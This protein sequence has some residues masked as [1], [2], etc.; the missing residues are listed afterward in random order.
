MLPEVMWQ[1]GA[2]QERFLDVYTILQGVFQE[3]KTISGLKKDLLIW[4]M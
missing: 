3:E 1:R 4:N 2:E